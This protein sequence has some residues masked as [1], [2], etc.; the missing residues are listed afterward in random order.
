MNRHFLPRNSPPTPRKNTSSHS[1]NRNPQNSPPSV[2]SLARTRCHSSSNA[3]RGNSS[4]R[5]LPS[6]SNSR[7][8][9]QQSLPT[10]LAQVELSPQPAASHSLPRNCRSRP[11]HLPRSPHKNILRRWLD[12]CP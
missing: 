6:T 12:Q 2:R 1:S 11:T 5:C 3:S 8:Y 7:L 9:L 4:P 10:P